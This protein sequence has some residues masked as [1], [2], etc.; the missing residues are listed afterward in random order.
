MITARFDWSLELGWRETPCIGPGPFARC[1]SRMMSDSLEMRL[2]RI[3]AMFALVETQ[4]VA[5]A[6]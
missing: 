5:R 4:E 6:A 3:V 2:Q 1:Y